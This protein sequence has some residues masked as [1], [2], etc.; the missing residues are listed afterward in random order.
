[1]FDISR[2]QPGDLLPGDWWRVESD[3]EIAGYGWLDYNWGRWG[4][5]PGQWRR[6]ISGTALAG[7]SSI[8]SR[9]KAQARGVY[10]IHNVVP[11]A[12]PDKA[13]LYRW[14]AAHGFADNGEGRLMRAVLP[15]GADSRSN[16]THDT[17]QEE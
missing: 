2:Y 14:L 15:R 13:G 16:S 6:R 9:R 8:C 11:A 10:Y 4:N 17:S 7:S 5:P 1:M 3:R 12:H